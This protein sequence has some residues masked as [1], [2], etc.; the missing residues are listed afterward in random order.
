MYQPSRT[1]MYYCNRELLRLLQFAISSRSLSTSKVARIVIPN[2]N[3]TLFFA[4]QS[5]LFLSFKVSSSFAILHRRIN[6][7]IPDVLELYICHGMNNHCTMRGISPSVHAEL[8]IKTI[9]I[10]TYGFYSFSA[11]IYFFVRQY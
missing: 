3:D 2:I 5:V 8:P 10:S 9:D 6:D 11:S 1:K 7:T 4:I